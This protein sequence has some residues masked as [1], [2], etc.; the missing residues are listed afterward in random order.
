MTSFLF[1]ML[2][3]GWARTAT[4]EEFPQSIR[5]PISTHPGTTYP[6]QALHH[7]EH[8]YVFFVFLTVIINFRA[9]L[10]SPA[11]CG[12]FDFAVACVWSHR[13]NSSEREALSDATVWD[14]EV[15]LLCS[16]CLILCLRSWRR[17]CIKHMFI[18]LCWCSGFVWYFVWEHCN[19]LCTCVWSSLW[20]SLN[21]S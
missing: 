11:A 14:I 8:C 16:C 12:K 10:H 17:R 4:T 21:L 1:S 15:C 5:A 13:S 6:L 7:C 9:I 2:V 18:V 20:D 19:Y 3:L